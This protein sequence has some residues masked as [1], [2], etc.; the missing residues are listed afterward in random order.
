MYG[1]NKVKFTKP[2]DRLTIALIHHQCINHNT[3]F[4]IINHTSQ[5]RTNIHKKQL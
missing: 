5:N 2:K 1:N 3:I 4:N